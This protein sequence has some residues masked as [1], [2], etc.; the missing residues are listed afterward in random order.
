MSSSFRSCYMTSGKGHSLHFPDEETD[1]GDCLLPLP[2]L[3]PVGLFS[4]RKGVQGGG[5]P[6]GVAPTE[7]R[8]H[9]VC[10]SPGLW[11]TMSTALPPAVILRCVA[12]AECVKLRPSDPTV[13]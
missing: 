4:R 7:G 6:L 1:L 9:P 12:A 3:L 13:P 8:T 11:L 5:W 10:C 2:G